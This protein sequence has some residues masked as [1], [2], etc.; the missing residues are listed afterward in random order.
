MPCS[1][2]TLNN[3]LMGASPCWS[4]LLTAGAGHHQGDV[5]LKPSPNRAMVLP[6]PMTHSRHKT[7]PRLKTYNKSIL[8]FFGPRFQRVNC[9][10]LRSCIKNTIAYCNTL[11]LLACSGPSRFPTLHVAYDPLRPPFVVLRAFKHKLPVCVDGHACQLL[12]I[13]VAIKA[14][15]IYGLGRSPYCSTTVTVTASW[16]SYH[17]LQLHTVSQSKAAVA[18]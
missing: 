16:P 9:R 3:Q 12:L 6:S 15:C 10:G 17:L 4:H 14:C 7:Q 2:S 13:D 8:P 1:R 11:G 18:A 5:A